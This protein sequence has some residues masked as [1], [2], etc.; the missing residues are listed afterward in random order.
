MGDP[1]R[2]YIRGCVVEGMGRV[3]GGV[4]EGSV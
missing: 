2:D 4:C 3:Y 1:V